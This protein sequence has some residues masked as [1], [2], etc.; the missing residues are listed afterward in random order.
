[1]ETDTHQEF[2]QI[3]W[4]MSALSVLFTPVFLL[5]QVA[6]CSSTVEMNFDGS[7]FVTYRLNMPLKSVND[8]IYLLFR[9]IKP[10]GLLLH[11]AGSSGDFVTLELLR[12]KLRYDFIQM[13]IFIFGY[14]L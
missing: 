3:C 10:S 14:L 12:G 1:M 4:A 2:I 8:E 11:A 13:L 7:S 9:S 5:V 6:T